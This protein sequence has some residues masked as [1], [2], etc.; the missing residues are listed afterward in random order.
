MAAKTNWK[1]TIVDC[2]KFC[3]KFAAG[4]QD[5]LISHWVSKAGPGTPVKTRQHRCSELFRHADL[6][7]ALKART[8]EGQ[9]LRAEAFLVAPNGPAHEHAAEGV[10][11]HERRV[12]GP[13]VLHPAGV[14]HDEARDGLEGDER[15][16]RQ[17]PR[18][19]AGVQPVRRG[20]IRCRRVRHGGVACR[21]EAWEGGRR[22]RE[23]VK[24]FHGRAKGTY[25]LN[26]QDID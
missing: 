10:E 20:G 15:R 26:D 1:Y 8:D 12:D 9:H 5:C 4:S 19:V 21:S 14:Q 17:L 13:F 16:G 2:G 18:V 11:R 7:G 3:T 23:E 24:K 25:D 22:M 6:C